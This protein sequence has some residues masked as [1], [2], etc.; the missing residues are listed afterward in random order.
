L[1][2]NDEQGSKLEQIIMNRMQKVYII[3]KNC[4]KKSKEFDPYQYEYPIIKST[5]IE[6]YTTALNNLKRI[7]QEEDDQIK[8][9]VIN[10]NDMLQLVSARINDLYLL[11]NERFN[12]S[13]LYTPYNDDYGLKRKSLQK[14]YEIAEFNLKQT[15]KLN[16]ESI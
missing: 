13:I 11:E 2:L 7:W 16:D 9:D 3:A 12:K 14:E 10:F 8:L 1:A 5:I 15:W 4:F 6:Q